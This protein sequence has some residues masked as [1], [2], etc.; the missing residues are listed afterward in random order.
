MKRFSILLAVAALAMTACSKSET[1]GAAPAA[2]T[3]AIGFDSHVNKSSRALTNANLAKFYVSGAYTTATNSTPV[4]IFN[5]EEV[6][7]GADNIWTYAGVARYWINGANYVFHAYSDENAS[8][9]KARVVGSTFSINEYVVDEANQKDLVYAYKTQVGKETGNAKVAFDFKH[10]LTKVCFN[11]ISDF[12]KG[13]KITVDEAALFNFRNQ[14]TFDGGE[15]FAWKNVDRTAEDVTIH[16]ALSAA[17]LE[18]GVEAA[19]SEYYM[20]PFTYENQNV[21]LRF[22]LTVV[23][24]EGEKVYQSVRQASFKP[25]WVLGSAY[26]YNVTLT[27][28]EAGLEKI[29]FE[30]DQNM[31]LDDWTT[32]TDDIEFNFGTDVQNA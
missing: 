25:T 31:N 10:V 28:S 14:G 13:Y 16:L 27:G 3:K 5:G 18:N 22:R 23:N 24:V 19:T 6:S 20:L 29:E 12:P 2:Q 32:G 30:T 21:R 11:F 15:K 9:A 1:E 8:S 7:K 17:D 4:Q 26:R